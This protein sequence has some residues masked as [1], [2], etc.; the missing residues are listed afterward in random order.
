M[1]AVWSENER[2]GLKEEVCRAHV[3]L[4]ASLLPQRLSGIAGCQREWQCWDSRLVT[5]ACSFSAWL[6]AFPAWLFAFPA[7]LFAFPTWLY[8]FP[9]WLFA[10]LTWLYAFPAWLYAFPAWLCAFPAWSQQQLSR[11]L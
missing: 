11:L 7:W 3:P 5:A 1:D 6:Y 10:F 8:A 9:A 4:Q 2:V